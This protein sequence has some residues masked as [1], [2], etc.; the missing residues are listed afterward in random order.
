MRDSQIYQVPL[1]VN[2]KELT[3]EGR[4]RRAIVNPATGESIGELTLASLA[5]IDLA[6]ETARAGFEAWRGHTPLAR[7]NILA[8]TASTM[9][10]DVERLASL[11]TSE[12]GKTLKEARAEVLGSADLVQW[13]GEEGKRLYGRVVPSRFPHM[14]QLVLLDPVGPV[15]AFSAWNYPISLAA[16]KIGHALAAGCSVVIKPAEECP[17][18]VLALARMFHAAGVPPAALQ[19]LFGHPAQVSERL[20]SSPYIR[21]ITFTGSTSVGRHL[22]TLA[23]AALKKVTFELGGHAPVIVMDD[24]DIDAFV[25]AAVASKYRNAGQI[26]TAPSRFFVH[27]RVYE[28]T[29]DAFVQRAKSLTVG[30]GANGETDMG[31]LAQGRRVSAMEELT[32]DALTHGGRI[33]TGGP[34]RS[35]GGYF[36]HP[37]VLTDVPDTARLMRE[38][39]FGP[40]AS[41]QPVNGL[42]HAL[43]AANSTEYGLAGYAFTS[44]IASARRIQE[45]L[46]VG[47]VG[48]NTF[49]PSVPEMPFAGVRDSGMGAAMGYE[50]LM[51]HMNVKAVFRAG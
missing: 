4:E 48:L 10:A 23:G 18:A 16:R 15:A 25:A 51:E 6:A 8:A 29:V 40:V 20:I 49:T 38:E 45:G 30:D 19:V 42:E 22:A 24:A 33:L 50:G 1:L 46:R 2:G 35:G 17:S 21:K 27:E 43:R 37:T 12:Q 47:I 32:H 44:T 11:L 41:F 9:R 3:G 13:L 7:A 26:C 34:G 31:P 14:E 28:R 5:D 39:P 36:W